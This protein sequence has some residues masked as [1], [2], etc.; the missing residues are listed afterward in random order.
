MTLEQLSAQLDS[1]Q[2]AGQQ[3][4]SA[5]GSI[6]D[7]AGAGSTASGTAVEAAEKVVNAKS[8]PATIEAAKE[9]A[10]VLAP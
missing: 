9:A 8:A 3:Q 6:N 4:Q 7:E 5:P 2:A 1:L 10:S